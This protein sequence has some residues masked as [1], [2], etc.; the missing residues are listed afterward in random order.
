MR[1]ALAACRRMFRLL[2]VRVSSRLVLTFAFLSV[3]AAGFLVVCKWTPLAPLPVSTEAWGPLTL[4][5]A[6]ASLRA[7]TFL[8]TFSMSHRLLHTACAVFAKFLRNS[9]VHSAA[10]RGDESAV[11]ACTGL[12][13]ESPTKPGG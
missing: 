12:G 11:H 1:A 5:R 7:H 4:V 9:C 2:S 6:T 10:G 3:V 13:V 8:R